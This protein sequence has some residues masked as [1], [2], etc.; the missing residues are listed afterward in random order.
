M[1]PIINLVISPVA[2]ARV[3]RIMIIK[4]CSKASQYTYAYTIHLYLTYTYTIHLYLYLYLYHTF[5]P[6]D[7][8]GCPGEGVSD[9]HPDEKE[10]EGGDDH[11]SQTVPHHP[12][13]LNTI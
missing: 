12:D 4:I 3:C 9:H 11:P 7:V 6:G 2:P 10:D 1:I 5:K 8:S 13:F